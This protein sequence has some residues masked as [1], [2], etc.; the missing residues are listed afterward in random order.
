[1]GRQKYGEVTNERPLTMEEV[2][3]GGGVTVKIDPNGR[4]GHSSYLHRRE[5]ASCTRVDSF[6]S[7]CLSLTLFPR[8]RCTSLHI[9]IWNSKIFPIYLL[10]ASLAIFHARRARKIHLTPGR[11][12][13]QIFL[14]AWKL[15]QR[16]P[17]VNS[18]R[19]AGGKYFGSEVHIISR[20]LCNLYRIVNPEVVDSKVTNIV[21]IRI[22]YTVL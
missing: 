11:Y 2:S 22:L 1:M 8:V 18:R 15:Y 6:L 13:L 20:I 4:C 3:L 7:S 21:V 9:F 10:F 12:A 17:V 5:R 19:F 14:P 16:E